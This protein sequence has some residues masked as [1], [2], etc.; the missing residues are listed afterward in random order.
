MGGSKKTEALVKVRSPCN[1]DQHVFVERILGPCVFWKLV[2]VCI[3]THAYMHTVIHTYRCMNAH[4]ES[5]HETDSPSGKLDNCLVLETELSNQE[6]VYTYVHTHGPSC[7]HM[8]MYLL[9]SVCTCCV[10]EW[11]TS[12]VLGFTP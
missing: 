7:W 1:E 2:Y 4:T 3:Y 12:P 5:L 11:K 6:Y 9:P 8:G 10:S